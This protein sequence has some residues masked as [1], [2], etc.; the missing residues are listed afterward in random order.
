MNARSKQFLT[1]FSIV[2]LIMASVHFYIFTHLVRFLGLLGPQITVAAFG[3]GLIFLLTMANLPL[4]RLLPRRYASPLAWVAYTWLG[5]LFLML[6]VCILVDLGGLVLPLEDWGRAPGYIALGLVALLA[7]Y[8]LY[9]ARRLRVRHVSVDIRQLH[10]TLHEL[11]IVQVTDL[12]VGSTIDGDWLRG[13]VARVNA[14]KPDVIAITGDLVDGSVA[15]LR[16]HVAPL[17]DLVATHGV[18]FVT[19]N[20]E[21]FSGAQA[22]VEYLGELGVRVLRNERITIG[23]GLL[24]IAGVDDFMGRRFPGHG[25]DFMQALGD[26]DT[27]RPVI[28]LA[29]QPKAIVEAAVHGVDL[30]ISGHTHGGQ[31]WPFRHLVPLQQP[32]ITGLHRHEGGATQIYIS[33]GTGYWGPPMR[34]GTTSEITRITLQSVS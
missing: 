9:N 22:W 29:H 3:T 18:Y 23:D 16:E 24:D 30:V 7:A 17:R 5:V 1:F 34:L 4:S 32:Y 25:P 27:S 31:I 13:V 6:V 15:E 12:H 10:A 20:H 26:R 33:A 2:F 28:L 19:G 21:Y 11:S 14:L 8:A